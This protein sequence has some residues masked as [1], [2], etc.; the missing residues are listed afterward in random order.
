MRETDA[1]LK[2]IIR[3][4]DRSWILLYI[5]IN[6]EDVAQQEKHYNSLRWRHDVVLENRGNKQNKE[7]WTIEEIEKK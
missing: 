3:F 7:K 2:V 1:T 5:L 4:S 6:G